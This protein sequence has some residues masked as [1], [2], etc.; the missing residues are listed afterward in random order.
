MKVDLIDPIAQSL[1]SISVSIY[2]TSCQATTL[3]K[4]MAL[5]A[6]DPILQARTAPVLVPTVVQHC[7]KVMVF[8]CRLHMK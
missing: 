4:H 8:V 1:V 5:E 2:S 3:M 6:W 7:V